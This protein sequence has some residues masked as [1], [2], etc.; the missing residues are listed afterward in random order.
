MRRAALVIAHS[1]ELARSLKQPDLS[2]P[3][4]AGILDW[5]RVHDLSEVVANR[6][7]R[8]NSVNDITV[9]KN[10]VG[11]GLQFAAVAPRVYER[12]RRAG[13]GHALPAELFLETLKP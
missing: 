1:K 8:R 12:A 5:D 13:L 3:V 4:E 6:A 9:F 7:P 2:A 10:N 11:L